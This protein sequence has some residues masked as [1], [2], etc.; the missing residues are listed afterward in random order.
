MVE[1]KNLESRVT[2]QMEESRKFYTGDLWNSGKGLAVKLP[3]DNAKLQEVANGFASQNV[4]EEVVDRR[5]DGILGREPIWT[6]PPKKGDPTETQVDLALEIAEAVTEWWNKREMLEL[7]RQMFVDGCL[8]QRVEIRPFAPRNAYEGKSLKN[9]STLAEALDLLHFQVVSAKSGAVLMEEDSLKPYSIYRYEK[10]GETFIEVSLTDDDGKTHLSR[11]REDQVGSLLPTLE[12]YNQKSWFEQIVAIAKRLV[13][14]DATDD[15]FDYAPLDLDGKLFLYE[16]DLKRP[17]VS[18][19]MKSLQ[20]QISLD[21]TMQGRNTYTAGFRSKHWLN[22]KAPTG[23]KQV[24]DA[25]SPT[26][27]RTETYNKP[28]KDG[29]GVNS[30]IQGTVIYDEN[31]QFKGVA[32][33]N[34]V[35]TDPVSPDHFISSK[36]DNRAGILAMA[37]Q[38]HVLISDKASVSGVSRQ[39]ARGEFKQDLKNCKSPVD[40]LG[41]Y[42][43]EFAMMFAANLTGRVEEFKQFRCD[44]NSIVDAGVLSP[45]EKDDNRKAYQ[46]G[47]I[48]LET[49]MHRNGIEDTSAELTQIKSEDGFEINRLDKILTVLER[50]N[51]K[52]PIKMQVEFLVKSLGKE[53]EWDIA[54]IMTELGKEDAVIGG[55]LDGGLSE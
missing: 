22:A 1:I 33:P 20:K 14:K 26:G 13:N 4:I 51:G 9:V 18:E 46:A 28:M 21:K 17:F 53:D 11:I 19:P 10:D 2:A 36:A 39:D 47:E 44:F 35:V 37:D 31:G 23:K 5:R 7:M 45:E 24:V 49:L 6:L 42:I 30:F 41:R 12:N 50:A 54:E 16:L 40:S 48:S 29:A 3:T 52:L 25:D 8:D 38:L 15:R 27:Y 43:I 34:V 55:N 32:T